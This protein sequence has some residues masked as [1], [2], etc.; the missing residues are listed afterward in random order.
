MK[1][2]KI[3]QSCG[4]PLKKDPQGGGTNADGSTSLLY[5]SHCFRDG[6]FTRPGITVGEMKALVKEKLKEMNFPGFLAVMMTLNINKL[7]RWKR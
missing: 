7:G 3:C 1:L 4:M 6:F 5:C 2:N